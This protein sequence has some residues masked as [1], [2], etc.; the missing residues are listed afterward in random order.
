MKKKPQQ[1]VNGVEIG[2][3]LAFALARSPGPMALKALARAA[4]LPPSKTHRYL[5]SLCR[6]GVVR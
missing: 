3:R 4:R 5:V 6:A 1:G 2:L